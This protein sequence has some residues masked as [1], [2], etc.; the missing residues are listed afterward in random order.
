MDVPFFFQLVVKGAVIIF[1]VAIDGL[2]NLKR[3]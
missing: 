1:A 3:T 2:K